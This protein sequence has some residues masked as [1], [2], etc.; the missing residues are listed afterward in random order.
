LKELVNAE[1]ERYQRSRRPDPG[2]HCP[3]VRRPGP[4]ECEFGRDV[5]CGYDLFAVFRLISLHSVRVFPL[6]IPTG[7]SQLFSFAIGAENR[8]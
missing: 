5:Q 2:H 7:L 8:A 3:F 4:L 6:P 1:T